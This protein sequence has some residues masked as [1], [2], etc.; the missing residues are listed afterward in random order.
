MIYAVISLIIIGI[1][2]Y[3]AYKNTADIQINHINLDSD[4]NIDSS[5]SI[6]HLSDFHLENISLTPHQLAKKL[7]EKKIDFIALTGDFLDRKRSI[8][9]LIPYL[10][11]LN[12]TQPKYGI[13]AVL[14]NHDYVLKKR[15]FT[16]PN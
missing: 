7:E 11:V 12:K 4:I 3:K 5:L 13:Y 14:G 1:I 6:L 15:K 9:K 10:Q 8:P 16:A 2:L